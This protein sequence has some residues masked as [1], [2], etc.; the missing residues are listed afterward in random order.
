VLYL[1]GIPLTEFD[2]T[3]LGKISRRSVG[4]ARRHDHVLLTNDSNPGKGYAGILTSQPFTDGRTPTVMCGEEYLQ[5]LNDG[6]IVSMARNGRIDILY[7]RMSE[8]SSL[9]VTERCNC[10][11][12]MCPQFI[13]NQEE[14]KTSLTLRLISLIDRETAVIGI[15]GGEPTLLG[16][17]LIEI[18]AACRENLPATKLI[19]LTNGIR[20]DD[21]DYVKKLMLV[22]HPDLT[23]DIPL[24]S[25]TD[26][27]HNKII[28]AKGFY[29]TINGLYNLARFN[30]RIG[31]RVVMHDLTYKRLPQLAEFLY[32]NFPFVFHIAFM[33]METIHLARKNI[34][35]L[36]ID[37]HEYNEQL[38]EAVLYLWRRG[39]NVSIYNAQLCVLKDTLWPFARK[40]I[41]TWKNVYLDECSE[42]DLR[43]IC[44][45]LFQSSVD[46]HSR[47][48]RP[49]KNTKKNI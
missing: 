47:Y 30:Q 27:E 36:W 4:I 39:M 20:L 7:E 8:H 48:L 43:E 42:C 26:T 16:D 13:N 5:D 9:L 19:L 6:D 34:D 40:S 29:R 45:G 3:I 18:V 17:E 46:L 11:C 49:L 41:S 24:Y 32:H 33:E 38:E 14:N 10:S 22:Q 2:D 28:G 1:T 21:F 37:P 35:F 25:D 23:I 44:G 15:T 31:I 12:V